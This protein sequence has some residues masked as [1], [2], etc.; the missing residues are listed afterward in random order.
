MIIKRF[1]MKSIDKTLKNTSNVLIILLVVTVSFVQCGGDDDPDKDPIASFNVT[2]NIINVWDTILFENTSQHAEI[3]EWDF[4]D[5]NFSAEKNPTHLY[6]EEGIYTVTLLVSKGEQSD[7]ATEEVSIII[8][9]WNIH[10][11]DDDV[12]APVTI[13][14]ADLDGDGKEDIVIPAFGQNDLNVYLNDFPSW[15]KETINGDAAGVTFAFLGDMDGDG[16][17]DIVANHFLAQ[18]IMLYLNNPSGW[19]THVV[20]HPTENADYMLLGDINGDNRLDVVAAPLVAGDVVWYENQHPDWGPH[21]IEE[22]MN[23]YSSFVLCDIDDNG[24]LDIAATM[25]E[26]GQLV[27]FQNPGSDQVWARH[28]IEASFPEIWAVAYGDFNDDGMIDLVVNSGGPYPEIVTGN[29]VAWYE[30]NYPDWTGHVIDD[31]LV[32]AGG[33]WVAD[34]NDNGKDDIMVTCYLADTIVWYEH[35]PGYGWIKHP[36]ANVEGPRGTLIKDLDGD[37]DKDVIVSGE[38]AVVW[39]EHPGRL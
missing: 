35:R 25:H 34:L 31:N 23:G 15:N 36:V 21:N 4:G 24:L 20:D 9:I 17:V 12:V 18:T 27:W 29:T 26:A 33:S 16:S 38:N 14:M 2:P 30:N 8:P 11:I 1:I 22:G 32:G 7:E 10:T 39:L 6:T 37:G 28:T 3:F 19:T 13:D 5:G